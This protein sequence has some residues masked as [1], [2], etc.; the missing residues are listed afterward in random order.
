MAVTV[1]LQRHGSLNRPFFHIVAADRRSS[2]KTKFIEKVGYY[3][4]KTN[5]STIEIKA[6]R[7]QHY[8]AQGAILSNTVAKFVKI[9][10]LNLERAKTNVAS[11]KASKAKAK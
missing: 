9:K 8:F 11:K 10:K 2:A 5:P 1:R 7:L 6:D 3:D 4:P